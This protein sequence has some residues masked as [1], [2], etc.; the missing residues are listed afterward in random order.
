MSNDD[1]HSILNDTVKCTLFDWYLGTIQKTAVLKFWLETRDYKASFSK[2]TVDWRLDITQAIYERYLKKGSKNFVDLSNK[3]LEE[4]EKKLRQPS[5]DLFDSAQEIVFNRMK[6]NL[7]GD[8][9]K[10][11]IY[12]NYIGTRMLFFRTENRTKRVIQQTLFF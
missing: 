8:F 7:L 12:K 6:N 3:V 11:D 10:S 1:L 2:E 4:I 9:I 5:A